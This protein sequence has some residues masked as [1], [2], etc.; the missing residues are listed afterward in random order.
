MDGRQQDARSSSGHP[1]LGAAAVA[2]VASF[3][4]QRGS[5]DHIFVRRSDGSSCAWAFP[6]YGDR[7]PH[8]LCHL[9]I[10]AMLG[11]ADGFWGLVDEGMEVQLID[12][13]ATLGKDGRPLAGRGDVDL[14][15]LVRAEEAVALFGP[16]GM[17]F[18]KTGGLVVATT[19]VTEPSP[20]L[21]GG[22]AALGF[23]LPATADKS[24]SN[25]IRDRLMQLGE[26]W[27]ALHDGAAITLAFETPATVP[28][29]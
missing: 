26:E 17:Q 19:T 21:E 28:P 11:I 12:D 24:I 20:A 29:A 18:D 8:D 2:L 16:A 15:G 22:R 13:Q 1:T 27:R 9:V 25:A 5:R 6:T 10:E 4:R 14:S 3:V 7:L 23:S